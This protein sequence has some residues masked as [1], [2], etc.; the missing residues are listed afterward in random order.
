MEKPQKNDHM[1]SIH[2]FI[3]R[4][5]D[6]EFISTKSRYDKNIEEQFM[7]KSI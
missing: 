5:I 1:N 4:F 6:D 7:C 3:E 2:D